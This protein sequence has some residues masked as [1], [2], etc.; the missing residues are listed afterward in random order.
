MLFEA[1]ALNKQKNG[2]IYQYSGIKQ[3]VL[4]LNLNYYDFNFEPGIET[5]GKI[6]REQKFPVYY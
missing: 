3:P 1:P 4:I 6:Y 2:L 5:S